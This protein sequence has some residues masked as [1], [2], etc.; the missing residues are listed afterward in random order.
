M[1]KSVS[2]EKK[3]L[4][5]KKERRN[6]IKK[7]CKLLQQKISMFVR[8]TSKSGIKLPREL[9]LQSFNEQLGTI[10][11]FDGLETRNLLLSQI[12]DIEKITAEEIL[13]KMRTLEKNI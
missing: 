9:L 3:A 4:Q 7:I 5:G 11:V 1:K 10:R 13:T 6:I 2:V 8:I 12:E